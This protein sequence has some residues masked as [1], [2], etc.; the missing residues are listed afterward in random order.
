M[1][2]EADKIRRLIELKKEYDEIVNSISGRELFSDYN[3]SKGEAVDPYWLNRCSSV[4]VELYDNP[5]FVV[6]FYEEFEY[7]DTIPME[8]ILGENWNERQA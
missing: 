5:G 2:P 1:H 8:Y 6:K 3:K 4:G 7:R